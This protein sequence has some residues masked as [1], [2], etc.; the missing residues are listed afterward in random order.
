MKICGIISEYNPFHKGHKY[1][2]DKTKE[3]TN[4]DA[5]VCVMSG[6]F[7]QRGLP[8]IMDKWT[9][10]EL[11]L[12]NGVDLVL[13]LPSI[14]AVSSAEFFSF[15][16]ISLL[17]SLGII[18]NLSF[19]SELGDVSFLN[20]I[21]EILIKEP[22]EY[23][24]S[25]KNNLDLG[26]SYALA[27]NNALESYFKKSCNITVAKNENISEIINSSNNILAIEYCKSLLKLDSSITPVTVKREGGTYNSQNL[28]NIFS[29]ATAIRNSLKDNTSIEVLKDAVPTNVFNKLKSYSNFIYPDAMVPYLRFKALCSKDSCLKNIPEA[30]EG[31]DNKIANSLESLVTYEDILQDIKSKRYAM[32]RISRLLCQYFIG[33]EK[34]DVNT[35]RRTSCPYARVLGFTNKGQ[36]IL[37]T[38]KSTSAI[39]VYT[40]L[41]KE[42]NEI[43]DLDIQCTKAYSLLNPSISSKDDYLKK[44]IILKI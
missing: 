11:A 32:T 5:I 43:L 2:I 31:L 18:D 1:H 22:I 4:C 9:R 28:N 38:L 37:K 17:N 15:G 19:G 21:S 39:P 26:Y 23:L 29:S 24:T 27:R 13:E 7:V 14:Y 20:S 34:Y 40:K 25:L 41:P 10:T 3:L 42:S 35:L 16:A 12:E 30:S 6:N 8:S 44:P 36:N 33:F